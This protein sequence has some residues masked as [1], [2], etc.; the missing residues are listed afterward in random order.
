MSEKMTTVEWLFSLDQAQA[1]SAGMLFG[2]GFG[3]ILS[4]LWYLNKKWKDVYKKPLNKN[5]NK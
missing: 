5:G 1:F 4:A 3:I 2:V